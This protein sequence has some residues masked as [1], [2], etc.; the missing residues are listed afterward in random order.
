MRPGNS[1]YS[2]FQAPIEVPRPLLPI[3]CACLDGPLVER[4]VHASGVPIAQQF[5]SSSWQQLEWCDFS[6]LVFGVHSSW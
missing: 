2:R 3:S 1:H 4:R 5:T 6:G